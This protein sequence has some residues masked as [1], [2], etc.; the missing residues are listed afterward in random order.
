MQTLILAPPTGGFSG[1]IRTGRP[2]L[3]SS[4][5]ASRLNSSVYWRRN[6]PIKHLPAPK[7]A[8]Q[9]CPPFRGRVIEYGVTAV[10]ATPSL[11][12]AL[13]ADPL[14]RGSTTLRRV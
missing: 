4:P 1:Q 13:M 8:Y 5:T 11:L 14:F 6:V 3:A 7:G 10:D 12:A 9:R 2:L